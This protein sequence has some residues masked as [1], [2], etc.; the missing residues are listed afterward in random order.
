[1]FDEPMAALARSRECFTQ[2]V[3]DAFGRSVEEEV[4]A[5]LEGALRRMRETEEQGALARKQVQTLTLELRM[6]I[7]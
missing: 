6:L 3:R 1:M 7:L 2:A 4:Y 5:P